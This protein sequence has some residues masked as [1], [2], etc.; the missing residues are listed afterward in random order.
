MMLVLLYA[1]P[2]REQLGLYHFEVWL[3]LNELLDHVRCEGL[4]LVR[5]EV[6][7]Q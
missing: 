7:L 3:F 5:V 4:A 1:V 6:G 2:N